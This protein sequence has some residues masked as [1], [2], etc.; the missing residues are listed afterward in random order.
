MGE[1]RKNLG[2]CPQH[3]VLFRRL[4]A[5]E[6]LELFARLN[7]V[8]GQFIA[9]EVERTLTNVGVK[10]KENSFPHEMSG[11]QRRK[12]TGL[13]DRVSRMYVVVHDPTCDACV[14]QD[15]RRAG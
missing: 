5:K 15:P 14:A 1:I 10:E 11:G 4:T 12:L 6:H 9:N 13:Q 7:G 3:D 8:P 2:V